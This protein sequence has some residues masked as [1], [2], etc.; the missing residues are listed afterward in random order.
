MSDQLD[1]AEY[2]SD[3]F[4]GFGVKFLLLNPKIFIDQ[5]YLTRLSIT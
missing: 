2:L 3:G 5:S 4:F 1:N